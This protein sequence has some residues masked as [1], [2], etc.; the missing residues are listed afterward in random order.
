MIKRTERLL[1]T[2]SK[3][4]M[5]LL[6]FMMRSDRERMGSK[7]RTALRSYA[8]RDSG[9]DKDAFARYIRDEILPT[10]DVAT[11]K[12]ELE[13]DL[14]EFLEGASSPAEKAPVVDAPDLEVD[15]SL[16]F[17]P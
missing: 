7:L 14:A 2:F 16:D 1:V 13:T 9:F 8:Y 10:V 15:S 17:A 12:R 5:E 4:E 3:L 11:R 6:R